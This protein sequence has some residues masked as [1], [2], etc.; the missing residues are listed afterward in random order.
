MCDGQVREK[1]KR[2]LDITGAAHRRVLVCTN[3]QNI[4]IWEWLGAVPD[5]V[6]FRCQEGG[7]KN[8]IIQIK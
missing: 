2:A 6:S 1:Q 5:Y 4:F 3:S 7:K 8:Y